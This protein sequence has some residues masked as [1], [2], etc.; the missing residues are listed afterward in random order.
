MLT[1][2]EKITRYLEKMGPPQSVQS[3]AIS[4][5]A[6]RRDVIAALDGLS[7]DVLNEGDGVPLYQLKK[8]SRDDLKSH[9]NNM[10]D[11]AKTITHATTKKKPRPVIVDSTVSKGATT[12]VV[13]LPVNA[14]KT[15]DGKLFEDNDTAA[16][17]QSSLHQSEL[18]NEYLDSRGIHPKTRQIHA[19]IIRGWDVFSKEKHLSFIE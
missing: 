7:L 5:R 9:L 16:Q 6:S 11:S 17:H 8:S 4:L 14:F 15:S 2:Q 13:P 3:I 19:A 18:I 12:P 1:L 10:L